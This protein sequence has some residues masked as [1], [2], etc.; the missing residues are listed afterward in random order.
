MPRGRPKNA[1]TARRQ[2][3]LEIITEANDRLSWSEIARRC[4]LHSYVDAR[5]ITRDLQKMGRI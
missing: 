1:M 4:G 5:R 3:V 2:Q